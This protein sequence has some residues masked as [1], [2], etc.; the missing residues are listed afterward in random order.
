MMKNKWIFIFLSFVSLWSLIVQL[1][2]GK[3]NESSSCAPKLD[4]SRT[5]AN[6]DYPGAFFKFSYPLSA[7]KSSGIEEI[8]RGKKYEISI[9]GEGKSAIKIS[10]ASK[11][12]KNF[13]DEFVNS[14]GI[15][16]QEFVDENHIT[17]IRF[18]D[19]SKMVDIMLSVSDARMY[20]DTIVAS[21]EF[22]SGN[23][24][25]NA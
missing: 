12:I 18:Y 1:S 20:V 4:L 5:K 23:P 10:L 19:D 17:H 13:T 21:F 22:T 25:I 2:Y 11:N 8:E 24:L 16:Y 15:K 3:M 14:K 7:Q 9:S 6:F